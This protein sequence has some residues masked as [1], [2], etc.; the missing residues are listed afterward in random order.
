MKVD[1]FNKLHITF[2]FFAILLLAMEG[3]FHTTASDLTY[4]YI[5]PV[6]YINA[7]LF[8]AKFIIAKFIRNRKITNENVDFNKLLPILIFQIILFTM[9]SYGIFTSN[10]FS[11]MYFPVILLAGSLG[12]NLVDYFLIERN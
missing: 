3:L 4:N 2:L 5:I 9:I 12:N 7:L 11:G 10:T 8:V 6:I 1:R